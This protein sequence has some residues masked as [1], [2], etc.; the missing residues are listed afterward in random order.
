MNRR[1]FLITATGAGSAIWLSTET[2]KPLSLTEKQG[3]LD[4]LVQDFLVKTGVPSVL[5]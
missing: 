4:K 5:R 1:S 2:T 3:A